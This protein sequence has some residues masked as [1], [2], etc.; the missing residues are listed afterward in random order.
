[1]IDFTDDELSELD[2]LLYDELLYGEDEVVYMTTSY[3]K[4][5]N[6]LLSSAR[7][8]INGEAKKRR[9]RWA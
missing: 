3:G 9:L 7:E 2:D 5:K 6:R 8:K 4:R 1:M